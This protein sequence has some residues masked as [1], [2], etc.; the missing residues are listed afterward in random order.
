VAQE[1]ARYGT[2]NGRSTIKADRVEGTE[3][4]N[5][6]GEHLGEVEDVIIDKA[7]GKVAYAV[8]SFGGFLGIGEKYHPIP[9]SM[10]SYDTGKHGYVVPLDR[11][12]LTD[13]PAYAR[14]D[15]RYGDRNWNRAV[16][17]YYQ[18]PPYWA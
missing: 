14:G 11:G 2:G 15:M 7:S 17:D 8:M 12:K 10:L 3:V 5:T 16:Y 18:V 13:A 6:Q 1:R 9:W 4:Y